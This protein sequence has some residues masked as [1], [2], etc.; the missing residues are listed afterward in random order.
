MPHPGALREVA[1]LGPA[2]R[3][4]V[5]VHHRGHHLQ[6]GPDREGQ[7]A[8]AHVAGDLGEYHAHRV[9]HGGLARVDLLVL[10]GLAHGGP[11][12][13]GVLGGSPD[14]YRE[15]GFRWGTATSSSTSSGTTSASRGRTTEGLI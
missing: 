9:G 12:P 4:D 14:A 5:G 3:G 8:L 11:L 7:Q 13:R 10:V 2:C 1:A 15:A 6:P